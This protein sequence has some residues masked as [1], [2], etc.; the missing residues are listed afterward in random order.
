MDIVTNSTDPTHPVLTLDGRFDAFE[1]DAFRTTI[2]QLLAAEATDIT[3]DL[4]DVQ[5]I[6]S[7]ALAELVRAMKHCREGNGELYLAQLSDPVRVILELT[8]LDA[9]FEIVQAV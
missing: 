5:F 8:R 1:T 2:D 6:D 7:S 3:V 9:A 4:R